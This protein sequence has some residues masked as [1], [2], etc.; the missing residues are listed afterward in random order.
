MAEKFKIPWGEIGSGALSG[1]GDLIS[2][3]TNAYT[4]NLYNRGLMDYQNELNK[5]YAT[6]NYSNA[7]SLQRAGLEK[8]GYNPILAVNN[9]TSFAGGSAGLGSVNVADSNRGSNAM[10]VRNE[11]RLV[12]SQVANNDSQIKSNNASALK[13]ME[14]AKTQETVRKLN[15]ANAILATVN[16][17]LGRKDLSWK[18]RLYYNQI[19]TNI[20]N[21]QAN[22][23]G[24]SASV[25][26]AGASVT[27]A[28]ASML[29]AKANEYGNPTKAI[30]SGIR[31]LY[32]KATKNQAI[33][34]WAHNRKKQYH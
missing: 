11:S 33:V 12:A 15:E 5:D 16:A 26:S 32:D 7:Y 6:W 4:S 13:F 19:K 28:K 2:T 9:G 25:T 22:Q 30:T 29:N 21:A 18:D 20:M 23:V 3:Q 27:N 1:I 24:A 8:A 10:R 17:E 34:K 14:E 31:N